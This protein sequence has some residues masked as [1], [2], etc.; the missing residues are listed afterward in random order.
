VLTGRPRP[1]GFATAADWD[2]R[3]LPF[4][5]GDWR[6]ERLEG[7]GDTVAVAI[8]LLRNDPERAGQVPIMS[9]IA[10]AVQGSDR[11]RIVFERDSLAVTSLA[12]RDSLALATVISARGVR[13]LIAVPI[14]RP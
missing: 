8:T 9:R 7:T 3:L 14:G 12:I 2:L 10:L 6:T 4:V 13:D 5:K 1:H 11:K